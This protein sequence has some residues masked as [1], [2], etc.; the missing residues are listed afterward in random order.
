LPSPRHCK[1]CS[2]PYG[3][4]R[5]LC[6]SFEYVEYVSLATSIVD[7]LDDCVTLSVVGNVL[8]DLYDVLFRGITFILAMVLLYIWAVFSFFFRNDWKN[9]AHDDNYHNQLRDA[10]TASS[11]LSWDGYNVPQF[12]NFDG[13]PQN[14]HIT[15]ANVNPQG[16]DMSINEFLK[17]YLR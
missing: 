5:K 4:P 16:I 17:D 15:Y 6:K 9:F 13:M 11:Q 7:T 10:S 12:E 2:R 14:V 1:E 3:N 8:I